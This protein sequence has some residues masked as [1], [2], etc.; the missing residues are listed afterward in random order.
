MARTICT[1]LLIASLV[2]CPFRCLGLGGLT[3][4]SAE[5]PVSYSCCPSRCDAPS[6]PPVESGPAEREQTPSAP[7]PG[8][9]CNGCVCEG[10]VRMDDDSV[11]DVIVAGLWLADFLTQSATVV[12]GGFTARPDDG[13]PLLASAAGRSLRLVIQSLQI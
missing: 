11:P 8:C 5:Q 10:A 13:P 7:D 6:Q 1:L 2:A 3:L 9:H 4:A 12:C